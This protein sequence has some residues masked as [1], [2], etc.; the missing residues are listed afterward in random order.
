MEND[1]SH[2]KI[3][4]NLDF[5]NFGHDVWGIKRVWMKNIFREVPAQNK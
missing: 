3:V 4:Q 2:V 1:T 5:Q